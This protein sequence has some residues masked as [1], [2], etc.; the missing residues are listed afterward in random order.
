MNIIIADRARARSGSWDDKVEHLVVDLF[1]VSV[2]DKPLRVYIIKV[3][4]ILHAPLNKL[5]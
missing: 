1:E 5:V 4:Y 3:N 2:A